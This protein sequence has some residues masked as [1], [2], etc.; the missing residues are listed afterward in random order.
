MAPTVSLLE[1]PLLLE[2]LLQVDTSRRYVCEFCGSLAHI[3]SS[4]ARLTLYKHWSLEESMMH[5][6]LLHQLP[7]HLLSSARF[8]RWSSRAM[9]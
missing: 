8:Q 4:L 7:V 6:T 3:K 5:S 9:L 1:I 2:A